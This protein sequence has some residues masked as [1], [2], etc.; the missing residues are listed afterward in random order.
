MIVI[1]AKPPQLSNSEVQE[2]IQSIYGFKVSVSVL[3]SERDQNFL[4]KRQDGEKF[5]FKIS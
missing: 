3:K 5:V 1:S 2:V 4:I